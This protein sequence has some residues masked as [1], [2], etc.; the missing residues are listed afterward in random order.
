LTSDFDC[1]YHILHHFNPKKPKNT[2]FNQSITT[3]KSNKKIK[4]KKKEKKKKKKKKKKKPP[5]FFMKIK[6]VTVRV[7]MV[8]FLVS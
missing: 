3:N 2:K 1:Q 8:E 5:R 7:K 6:P 4:K